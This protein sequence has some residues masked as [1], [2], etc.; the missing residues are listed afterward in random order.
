MHTYGIREFFFSAALTAQNSPELHFRFIDSFIQ[1][2][3]VGSL[4]VGDQI[5]I[6]KMTDYENKMNK[7]VTK[8]NLH[9][10]SLLLQYSN[11]RKSLYYPV[12]HMIMLLNTTITTWSAEQRF[13]INAGQENLSNL[14]NTY[15]RRGISILFYPPTPP[16]FSYSITPARTLSIGGLKSRVLK[17]PFLT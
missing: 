1:P 10:P 3:L 12:W 15:Q 7:T 16:F 17:L 2:S 6:T 13:V 5:L 14:C 9:D 4:L 8:N 11:V